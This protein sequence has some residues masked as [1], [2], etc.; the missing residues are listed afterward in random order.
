MTADTATRTARSRLQWRVE[1]LIEGPA[2]AVTFAMML[3]ITANA[4]LRA[5]FNSP[6][7]N[8]LEITQ[9]WYLPIVVFLGFIAAQMR[10]QHVAA[11]VLYQLLPDT[12]KRYVLMAGLLLAAALC[13]AA[14][15]FGLQE[16][17]HAM[18]IR[19]TAGV[20]ALVAWPP[21][22]LAPIAFTSLTVQF[23]LNAIRSARFGERSVLDLYPDGDGIV[24]EPTSVIPG[25]RSDREQ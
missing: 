9:Y 25:D 6:L 16:A 7:P 13:A 23:G 2:V 22:F 3:H 19:K 12:T 1:Y 24:E 14:A 4:V 20:S 15:W 5:F 10:G 8:T 17:V 21:Y 18:D 11:D